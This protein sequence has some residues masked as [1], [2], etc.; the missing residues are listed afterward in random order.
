MSEAERESTLGGGTS[1]TS[2]ATYP[3]EAMEHW[4]RGQLVDRARELGI[5]GASSMQK[6]ELVR[7]LREAD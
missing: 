5:Q 7:V 2:G 4:T 1:T 6:D 3:P